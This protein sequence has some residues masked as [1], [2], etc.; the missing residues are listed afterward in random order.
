MR[1]IT[2]ILF[3]LLILVGCVASDKSVDTRPQITMTAPKY[4]TPK[5]MKRHEDGAKPT[6]NATSDRQPH[7]WMGE[8]NA[9]V[10]PDDAKAVVATAAVS[11]GS[12]KPTQALEPEI[13]QLQ[14]PAGNELFDFKVL[15]SVG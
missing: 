2:I 14:S 11:N 15:R 4:W 8:S 3:A 7:V 13:W 12:V 5:V 10:I 1:R 9:V 6:D